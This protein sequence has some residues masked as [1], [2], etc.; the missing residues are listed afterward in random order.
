MNQPESSPRPVVLIVPLD[1][2]LGHATRCIPIIKIFLRLNYTVIL[3]GEGSVKILLKEQFP[4]LQFLDLRGYRVRYSARKWT[5]PIVLALQIPAI[6]SAIYNENKWLKKV[7]REHQVDLVISDNR[8]GLY[9]T[10]TP[11]IF[12]T[13][14]LSIK[15]P[16]FPSLEKWL[17]KL[18]YN[19]IRQF[20]TC[21][22]PD[23]AK[24]PTLAGT[25]SHPEND[26]AVP[27]HYIGALS[28]L[29][30][31]NESFSEKILIILS[32]PE[33]QRTILEEMLLQQIHRYKGSVV[34]V[35]GL[36]GHATLPY[37]PAHVNIANHLSAKDLEKQMNSAALVISRCGYSTIMDIAALQKKSVLIPT[38]GQT[39]QEYL[40]MHLMEQN[41]ALC[42]PQH[43]LNLSSAI[44]L[45]ASFPYQFA[46]Y[47]NESIAEDLIRALI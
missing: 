21:W 32:G 43:K 27:V 6:I 12:I 39:E 23:T 14:Q 22:V 42:I 13:H 40:A 37:V 38:P 4:N 2:G 46:N 9:H 19:Y 41:F 30:K 7:I 5:L 1:W 31:T 16:R 36:P 8:Y 3:A 28:R 35:R 47:K 44:D 29:Q 25:L 33:P 26:P 15:I 10:K 11:C 24:A 17:Q 34:F 18:N 45:A 20:K